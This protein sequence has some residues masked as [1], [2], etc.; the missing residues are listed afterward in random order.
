MATIVIAEAGVNHNGDMELAK[1]LIE[2]AANAG[3]DYV[4]FQSF[5]ADSLVIPNAKKAP[6]Q[7]SGEPEEESQ[8]AMLQRL[9]LDESQHHLLI[10]YCKNCGIEFLSTGFDST[11]ISMLW[12]LGQRL[13]KVPSGE[14][15]NWFLLEQVAKFNCPIILSTGMSN[16]NEV[17]K[18]L[19][20]IEQYGTS[21]D[22]VTVM[23]CTSNYP[24]PLESINLKAMETMRK[25][26]G[27][28]VGYSD[29]SLGINVSLAAVA[30]GAT[31]IEKHF[32]LDNELPGPDHKSSLN[33]TELKQMISE[34]RNLEI[35]MGDGVKEPAKS[36]M[37]NLNVIRKSIVANSRIAKGEKF[38]R[39]NLTAKRPGTGIS[40]MELP[41]IVGKIANRDYEANEMI[42]MP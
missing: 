23:H 10:Q 19:D 27:V 11:S 21:R 22:K 37:E 12:N 35:I 32:T 6:Y 13:F 40:P 8:L 25:K 20:V 33:P 31:I 34:I 1:Q 7:L 4:K 5:I 16:L 3:A 30:Q 42:E 2:L 26:L 15:T 28:N 39:Q 18:A 38:T 41:N 29:H 24:A 9:Q 36:E 14:I 17:S